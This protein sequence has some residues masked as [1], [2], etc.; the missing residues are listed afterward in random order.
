MRGI[1]SVFS[2]LGVEKWIGKVP[3]VESAT[4]TPAA[5]SAAL[6]YDET[7][8]VTAPHMEPTIFRDV[9]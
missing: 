1:L 5:G 3:R 7:E 6:R 4:V 2:V 8:Q 9:S